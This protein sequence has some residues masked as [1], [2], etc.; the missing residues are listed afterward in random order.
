MEKKETHPFLI[1]CQERKK[2]GKTD[3]QKNYEDFQLLQKAKAKKL[4]IAKMFKNLQNSKNYEGYEIE[5][6]NNISILLG[7]KET[8]EKFK[9][10][11]NLKGVRKYPRIFGPEIE[12]IDIKIEQLQKWKEIRSLESKIENLY[13][14]NSKIRREEKPYFLKESE[15]LIF[16]I[17]K[18]E[19]QA[20][21]LRKKYDSDFLG[22]QT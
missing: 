3:H 16:A 15:S 14:V 21:D 5:R 7:L 13:C 10:G 11:H 18:L 8:F 6:I 22:W 1:F 9:N 19:K 2:I 20:V 12:K 4:L 17:K